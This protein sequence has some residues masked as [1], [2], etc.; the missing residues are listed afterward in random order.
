MKTKTLTLKIEI[1]N[2]AMTDH[3]D[4]AAALERVARR[5]YNGVEAGKI[6]DD[7]G[8]KVGSFQVEE[9]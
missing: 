4:I 9:E 2:D 8:N 1:G 3:A 7:N 5:V 6:I